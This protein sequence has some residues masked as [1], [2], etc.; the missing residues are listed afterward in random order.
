MAQVQKF[1]ENQELAQVELQQ[2][3]ASQ[4]FDAPTLNQSAQ[5]P[6]PKREPIKHLLIGSPKG[7]TSTINRLHLVGYANVGDWSQLLPTANPDEVMSILIRYI[8]IS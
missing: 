6:L 3:L 4:D 2:F 1:G 7:V 5:K 8:L